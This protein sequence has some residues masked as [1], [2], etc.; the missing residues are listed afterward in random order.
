MC[1]F[2]YN[3]TVKIIPFTIN[4]QLTVIIDGFSTELIIILFA[5]QAQVQIPGQGCN[6]PYADFLN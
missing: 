3:D 5:S 1:F 4:E 6:V 2:F